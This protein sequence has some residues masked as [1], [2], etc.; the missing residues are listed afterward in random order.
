MISVAVSAG[1]SPGF[2]SVAESVDAEVR[3]AAVRS[4]SANMSSCSV[5]DCSERRPNC[6]ANNVARRCLRWSRSAPAAS[7]K[8]AKK[9][10]ISSGGIFA[11]ATSRP[12]TRASR[13][14]SLRSSMAI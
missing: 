13:D 2:V 4:A 1:P 12:S 9:P 3:S 7:S 5:V 6:M 11:S 10:T 8:S 14:R